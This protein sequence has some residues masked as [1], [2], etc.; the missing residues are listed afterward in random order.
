MRFLLLAF[1]LMYTLHADTY[2]Y[3][4]NVAKKENAQSSKNNDFFMYGNFQEIIRFDKLSFE[5]DVFKDETK[6]NMDIS[7]FENIV[8]TI[9]NYLEKGETIKIK[10]IGHTNRVINSDNAYLVDADFYSNTIVQ[11]RKYLED[12]KENEKISKDY[13]L[14]IQEKLLT[15]DIDKSL[16]ILEYRKENDNAYTSATN[17]G[18]DLSK[19]VMLTIYV[20]KKEVEKEVQ[21]DADKDG[22]FDDFDKCPNTPLNNKVDK[23]G[24]LLDSDKDGVNDY[25]DKC[26]FTKESLEVDINGCPLTM[27]LT[28]NFKTDSDIIYKESLEKIRDFA[29]FLKKNSSYHAKIIGHTDNRGS[30][31]HNLLLSQNRAK[32]TK[33]LLIDEGVKGFRLTTL[34]EGELKP[35]SENTTADARKANRRIEVVLSIR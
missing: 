15:Y 13:A 27:T 29:N 21:K 12:T 14:I 22:V 32:S 5:D 25:L 16:M 8:K 4:Y 35:L 7:E 17:K 30:E 20:L 6:E 23:N 9:K 1:I 19:R 18:R 2:E 24:C 34:G 10:I 31:A 28:L 26:P 11:N 33:K 3:K